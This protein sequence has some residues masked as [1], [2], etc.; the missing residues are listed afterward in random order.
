M[1]KQSR[2]S[3]AE[4]VAAL[5]KAIAGAGNTIF[6]TI[7]QAAAANSAGLS[8]RPTTLLIF[9]NPKGGTPLMDAHPLAAL[10]LPLK[11]LVWE[12]GSAVNVAYT[13][14][15]EIASRY[16]IPADE[17][18]IAAMDRALTALVDSVA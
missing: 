12:D 5:S 11:L 13:P 2:S 16:G 4:T 1:L 18:H 14:A 7:D 6:A 17:P 8:L 9:G 10:D 3:F 15:S